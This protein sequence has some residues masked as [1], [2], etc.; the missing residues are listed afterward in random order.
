MQTFNLVTGGDKLKKLQKITG[1][2]SVLVILFTLFIA[3]QYSTIAAEDTPITIVVGRGNSKSGS[4]FRTNGIS[5]KDLWHPGYSASNV[6]RVKNNSGE[7]ITINKIGMTINLEKNGETL[8]LDHEDAKNYISNMKIKVD[9]KNIVDSTFKS[10]IFDGDFESFVKSVD[11]NIPI[12]KN[13]ELDL[14]YTISMENNAG[15]EVQGIKALVD[16]VIQINGD[17]L[18]PVDSEEPTSLKELD[19]PKITEKN[20]LTVFKPTDI[21]GHWAYDCIMTLI[22]QG[23][24]KGYPDGTIRPDD[25]VTRAETVILVCRALELTEEEGL[26][27]YIDSIPKWA[28]GYIK[29][30]TT[31]RIFMG[32]PNKTFKPNKNITRE[33]IL[34]ALM[35]AF[36]KTSEEDLELSFT[37]A[38]SISNWALEYVKAGVQHK[39]I[40]GYPDNTS[41]PKNN[42]TRAEAFTMI[43][44]LLGCHEEH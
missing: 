23:I 3:F 11:C 10:K 35:K 43:C 33:E 41:K 6:L 31:H 44:K 32:Y 1:L 36:S 27:G 17:S 40:E 34:V 9:Y 29:A 20:D 4:I 39:I 5:G 18:V 16:F 19:K 15:N 28:R 2:I 14:K 25:N 37:D 13:R 7:K 42:I 26:T 30:A 8:S 22:G 12:E 21:E 24:I 38:N